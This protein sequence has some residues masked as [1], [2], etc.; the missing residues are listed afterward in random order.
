MQWFPFQGNMLHTENNINSTEEHLQS[1]LKL[2]SMLN[3]RIWY[4]ESIVHYDVPDF[5]GIMFINC[6]KTI[7]CLL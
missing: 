5:V 1:L 6:L 2:F 4:D 3:I 7:G